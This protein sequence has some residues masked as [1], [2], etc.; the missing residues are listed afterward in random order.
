MKILVIGG[1]ARARRLATRLARYNKV[2]YSLAGVTEQ[3]RLPR[4]CEVRRGPFGG[5]AGLVAYLKRE[6]IERVIDGSHPHAGRISH[7]VEAACTEC[8]VPRTALRWRLWQPDTGDRWTAFTH[9]AEISRALTARAPCR[10]LL[11]LGAQASR[12]LL[13]VPGHHY[14]WRCV[15]PP[16]DG[17]LA[18]HITLLLARGPFTQSSEKALLEHHRIDLVVCKNSGLSQGRAKLH[19]ARSLGIEAWVLETG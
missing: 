8:R 13:D 19:A 2:T 9:V 4:D 5:V 6:H 3:P 7:N 17:V 15:E 1:T 11:A 16:A 18:P 10:V 12:P 14:V